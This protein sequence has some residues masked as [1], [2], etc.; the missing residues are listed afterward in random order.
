MLSHVPDTFLSHGL[1]YGI[2][3]V[4]WHWTVISPISGECPLGKNEDFGPHRT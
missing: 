1:F 4:L 3:L 2:G